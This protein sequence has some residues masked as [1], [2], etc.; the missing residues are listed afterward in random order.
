MARNKD[1]NARNLKVL[2]DLL[3]KLKVSKRIQIDAM[4]KGT[5][6]YNMEFL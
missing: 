5:F 2:D 4:A 1:D 3:V 6:Q